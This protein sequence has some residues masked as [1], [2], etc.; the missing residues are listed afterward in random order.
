MYTP[1]DTA[2]SH[3]NR[4]TTRYLSFLLIKSH[5]I[6]S[7][8][9]F[10]FEKIR[11]ACQFSWTPCKSDQQ[12]EYR[13]LLRLYRS[14]ILVPRF[15]ENSFFVVQMSSWSQQF[16]K[17]SYMSQIWSQIV[18]DLVTHCHRFVTDVTSNR[19]SQLVTE[20]VTCDGICYIIC[21][22]IETSFTWSSCCWAM[23]WSI[24]GVA[25]SSSRWS[26][27]IWDLFWVCYKLV[28]SVT[29]SVTCAIPWKLLTS[30][31]PLSHK[32][33]VFEKS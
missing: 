19:L 33:W 26:E 3:A 8:H 28:T 30:W 14:A 17:E 31:W 6:Q 1:P 4:T 20:F 27:Y 16:F 18:T 15:F 10:F 25:A 22:F 12:S 2:S 21:F 13:D 32:K 7:C 9:K 23:L 11:T 5:Q 29:K 24:D